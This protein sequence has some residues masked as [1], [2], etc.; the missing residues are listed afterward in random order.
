MKDE[1]VNNN[2]NNVNNYSKTINQKE[3][4][5]N[6][7][8]T[9]NH[10]FIPNSLLVQTINKVIIN[11]PNSELFYENIQWNRGSNFNNMKYIGKH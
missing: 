1:N 6:I 5:T 8:L 10:N 11:E 9:K 4:L 7:K 2:N 3:S